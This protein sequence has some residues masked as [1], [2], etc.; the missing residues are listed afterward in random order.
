[1]SRDADIWDACIIGCGATGSIVSYVL[2]KAGV[3]VLA[4]EAGPAW[5]PSELLPDELEGYAFEN[6]LGPKWNAEPVVWHDPTTG[7]IGAGRGL[8][9]MNGVGG[10]TLHYAGHA[11]RF[12]EDDFT[13]R[14]ATVARYGAGKLPAGSTLCDWPLRYSEL[15]PYYAAVEQA[16]GVSGAAGVRQGAGH[17]GRS[18]AP[19]KGNPFEAPRSAE[20]PMPPLRPHRLG[21]LIGK[22]AET[23]GYHPFIGPTAI[24][25]ID[26]GGR[27]AT[28]YCGFCLGHA[29]RIGAKGSPLVTVLPE[30]LWTGNLEILSEAEAVRLELSDN[31]RAVSTV[32]YRHEGEIR[33]CRARIFVLAAYVFETVRLLLLSRNADFPA[34]LLNRSGQVGRHFM[35]HRFDG[36]ACVFESEE[37]NRFAGPQ[38]QRLVIDD[39]NADN[40]DHSSVD[41]IRGGQI[42]APNE[43]HPIQDLSVVPPGVRDWGAAYRRHIKEYWNRT[44]LLLTNIETLPYHDNYLV[45]DDVRKD[46]LGRPLIRAR[47]GSYA[48]ERRMVTYLLGKMRELAFVAGAESAWELKSMVIPS[49]HDAGGAR[50]GTDPETS[51]VNAAGRG[52][53]LSNLYV[54]GPAVFPTASGLNPSLTAQALAWRTANE[55]LST[56]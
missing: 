20:Y 40:F 21:E 5:E 37:L 55:V 52:H 7:E 23:L 28:N 6:V 4:L 43:F 54:V 46:A 27:P 49:Q 32:V 24:N 42:F 19:G 1:M 34:G 14:S 33:R 12:H 47:V 25:S 15:E 41:F 11:W 35:A 29:C 13:A 45:L 3:R 30:A 16:I 22:A 48:N 38:G 56:L 31:G 9:M 10:S 17:E 44:G 26:Y 51:V 36:V 53:D 2:A 18:L 39:L 8:N 50:M